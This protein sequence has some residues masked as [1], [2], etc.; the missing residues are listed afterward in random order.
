M[1][2]LLFANGPLQNSEGLFARAGHW[3]LVIAVDGG[4]QHCQ[5]YGIQ[6]DLLIGDFD[7]LPAEL[8]QSYQQAGVTIHS[9]PAQ[10]DQTDLE[11]AL[12][13]ARE[14]GARQVTILGALGLR[15]DQT[16]AN[17]L[18]PAADPFKNMHIRILDGDQEMAVL[19]PGKAFAIPGKQGD[20]V[21]LIP[22]A[23]PTS[24][25]TTTGLEY[26]L[27][28]DTLHFAS[29]RGISNVIR[30]TPASVSITT[31]ILLCTVLHNPTTPI[32]DL[33]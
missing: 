20:T 24:G 15:W 21:S 31:G 26:P 25:I 3:D 7:S 30:H 23:G 8:L 1:H 13:A 4:G 5:Q 19:H 22:L 16:I 28:H 10:K 27:K 2:V 14:R 32:G 11:L 29:T 18:L 33:T 6:P 17:V 12:L 9:H